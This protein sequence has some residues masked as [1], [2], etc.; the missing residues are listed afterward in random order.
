MR[1]LLLPFVMLLAACPDPFAGGGSRTVMLANGSSNAFVYVAIDLRDGPVV[2]PN[3]A[4]D[5]AQ[6]PERII[7]PGEARPLDVHDYS[8]EGVLLFLYEIPATD[9]AGPVPLSRIVRVT[10]GDLARMH[11]RIVIDDE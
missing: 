4:I 7:A 11:N 8:G 2:D 5:P 10:A 1:A 6:V 9:Q 3:P